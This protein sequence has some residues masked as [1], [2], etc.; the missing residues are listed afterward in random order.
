MLSQKQNE[1]TLEV[2]VIIIQQC[3]MLHG[4][5]QLYKVTS[6]LLTNN[7]SKLENMQSNYH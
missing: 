7:F 2:A 5:F 4:V 6:Q 1:S 3:V